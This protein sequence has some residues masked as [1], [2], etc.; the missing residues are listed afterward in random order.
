MNP[1][2]QPEQYPGP[3][4]GQPQYGQPPG[5]G[6]QPFPVPQDQ[7]A[8]AEPAR[9]STVRYALWALL[10]A[11]AISLISTVVAFATIDSLVDAARQEALRTAPPEIDSAQFESV[12]AGAVY[13][14]LI[15]GL[16]FTLLLGLFAYLA[17]QGRNWAR[18]LVTVLVALNVVFGVP[19]LLS[20]Q[21][22]NALGG[23]L[24]LVLQIAG[25]VLF[26]LRPSSAFF[27]EHKR[28]RAARTMRG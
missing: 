24:A 25:V 6:D 19:A 23:A 26:W 16:V 14:G 2:Q 21:G 15:G 1:S 9:P 7:G 22:P 10:G 11:V 17:Y 13:G 8:M 18:T 28:L 4:Y 3:Q 12:I 5:Y 20:A 27:A